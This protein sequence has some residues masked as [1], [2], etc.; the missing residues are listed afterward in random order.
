LLILWI[1]SDIEITEQ[2]LPKPKKNRTERYIQ[3]CEYWQVCDYRPSLCPAYYQT[4]MFEGCPDK[5][6]CEYER[7]NCRPDCN[8]F[9]TTLC[10][11]NITPL[12]LKDNTG[13]YINHSKTTIP[14]FEEDCKEV[15]CD[16]AKGTKEICMAKCYDCDDESEIKD[17]PN[18]GSITKLNCSWTVNGGLKC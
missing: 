17:K 11:L 6:S 7:R 18:Y 2:K 4:S 16:C 14:N 13:V 15:I 1:L 10:N 12:H 5:Y 9:N 8:M 3:T